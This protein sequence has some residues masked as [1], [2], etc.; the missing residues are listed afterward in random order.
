[1]GWRVAL[2]IIGGVGWLAFLII[3]LFFY[4]GE[5]SG[6]Q[7]VA[8]LLLSLLV[9]TAVAGIPWA[10]WGRRWQNEHEAAVYQTAGF[11]WRVAISAV[12]ALG[13]LIFL[14]GWFY[15]YADD[16]SFYQNVAVVLVAILVM[17]GL[18]GALWAPW[19]IK[20]GTEFDEGSHWK[21]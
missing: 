4:A 11:R 5:Y 21:K 15:M 19:G 13:M 6:Y 18:Q 14:I 1:M 8:I 10:V 3:W 2:S 16:Y 12:V 17:G 7:N 20:H 9:V